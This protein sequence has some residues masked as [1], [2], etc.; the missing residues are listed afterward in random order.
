MAKNE[1]I[2]K[3]YEM[4]KNGY[5]LID[6]SKKLNVPESTIRTWESRHKWDK[7]LRNEELTPK[8]QLFCIYYIEEFNA[9]KSYQKAFGSSYNVSMVEGCKLLRNPKIK[10]EIDKLTNECLKENLKSQ[11]NL[12]ERVFLFY[13]R[14]NFTKY[15]FSE[16]FVFMLIL[17]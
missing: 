6:I 11:K 16:I 9:T 15:T 17:A 10:E 8:Q 4:Y 1:K 2:D 12:R 14:N 3:A 7:P 13:V 5:K